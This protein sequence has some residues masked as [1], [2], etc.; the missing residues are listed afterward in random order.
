MGKNP[1]RMVL[2]GAASAFMAGYTAYI[3]KCTYNLV[4]G[5]LSASSDGADLSP[6][7]DLTESI[8]NSSIFSATLTMY[9]IWF[10][11]IGAATPFAIRLLTINKSDI[12]DE[13][14][15]KYTG[16]VIALEFVLALVI[17][18]ILTSF[19]FIGSIIKIS[20]QYPLFSFLIFFLALR[21]GVH[22]RREI[23]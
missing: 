8:A 16:I 1:V 17:S 13:G 2:F 6:A 10:I 5:A 19:G 3:S 23:Y 18:I 12:V 15:L 22:A 7:V 20:W 11:L 4:A 9:I 14:E 21:K